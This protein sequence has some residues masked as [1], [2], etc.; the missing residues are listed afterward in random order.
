MAVYGVSCAISMIIHHF[1]YFGGAF[2]PIY[3]GK[4]SILSHITAAFCYINIQK[5]YI[6][7]FI[8]YLRLNIKLY[9]ISI[10][11]SRTFATNLKIH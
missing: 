4:L 3:R 9:S 1:G 8:V 5:C 2:F 11:I 6:M 7:A 10:V